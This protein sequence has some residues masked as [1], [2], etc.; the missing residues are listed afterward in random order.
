MSNGFRSAVLLAIC[1]SGR[2]QNCAAA[3]EVT[4]LPQAHA[5]N[6]YHHTTPLK[7]ALAHGFC[8]VE[9]DVFLVDGRLLVGHERSELD[10]DR[11]LERLYLDPL[12]ERIRENRGRVFVQEAPFQL[13]IDIKSGGPETYRALDEV[14]AT[15]SE[16]F[17]RV[18]EGSVH[19][20]PI[21]VVISGNRDWPT[22]TADTTR[23]AGIDGRLSDLGSDLPPHLLPWI[24]D[25]WPSH[26]TWDGTGE[27]PAG[28]RE[29]LT[30]IVQQA[31]REGRTVRFWATPESREMREVLAAAGVDLINTDDLAGLRDFLLER[32]R[33]DTD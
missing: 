9:A 7:D 14:L 24:S 4:P 19:P 11:T 17:T 29:K 21:R 8:S 12:Q 10:P 5:H 33:P 15:Y 13:L 1:W 3:A 32:A 6:D 2:S 20:G 22:I 28:E 26:F 23:F 31:H 25:R 16:L 18:E 30:R 27:I